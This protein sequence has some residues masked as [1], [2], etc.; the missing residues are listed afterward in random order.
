MYLQE[1][2]LNILEALNELQMHRK[3]LKSGTPKMHLKEEEEPQ[4]GRDQH[5]YSVCS[6]YS[7][8]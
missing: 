6:F 1:N 8:N 7:L 5:E 2:Q 4:P 3:E